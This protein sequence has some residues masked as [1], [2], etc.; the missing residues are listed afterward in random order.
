VIP[1]REESIRH[2]I[3]LLWENEKQ[4]IEGSGA[5]AA[6]LLFENMDLFEGKTV[7]LVLTGGNI[8]ESLLQTVL[9]WEK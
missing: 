4:I 8:D 6:A 1:V 5:A 9:A 3:Y 7:V 2:A